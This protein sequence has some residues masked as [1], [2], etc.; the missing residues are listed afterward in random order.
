MKQFLLLFFFIIGLLSCTNENDEGDEL[1]KQEP[2][3]GLTDSI[4]QAPSNAELYY[5]RGALL[6]QNEKQEYAEA[7]LKKAWQLKQDEQYALGV[8]NALRRKNADSAIYFLQVASQRLPQSIALRIALSRGLQQKEQLDKALQICDEI[9]A[10]YPNQLDALELKTE[11]LQ[12]QKKDTEALSTLEK[13]YSYAPS[14][15]ELAHRL[16][17]MYAEAKNSKAI[18][19]CDSLIKADVQGTHAE[20]YYFKG[21]YY[22]NTGN[23]A[24]ALSFFNQ[25]IQRNYNFLDAYMDKGNLLYESKKYGEALKTFELATTV[26]PTF[27]D[28][29]FWSA[30]TKEAMGNKAEAK[31]DYQRAYGLDKSL[32]EAKEAA[33]K[34]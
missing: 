17:F 33:D 34:L 11:L 25:A 14:D 10:A 18:A 32:T 7:D 27:A 21:V 15:P 28:A 5:K 24:L 9:L 31:L 20:P 3:A 23:R 12:V 22:A 29:Y 30:K 1:L 16:A 19:L 2:Y 13:A 26:S 4:K 8:A 6:L